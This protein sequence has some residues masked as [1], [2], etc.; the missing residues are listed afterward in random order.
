MNDFKNK[1]TQKS[2]ENFEKTNIPRPNMRGPR[3]GG[4]G[5]PGGF[6]P[7]DKVKDFKGTLKK[8]INYIGGYK[9][10]I[11]IVAVFAIFAAIFSIIGPKILGGATTEVFSGVMRQV[12]G[13]DG[14]DFGIIGNIILTLIILYLISALFSLLQGLIMTKISNNIT[15]KLRKEL[16]EKIYSLPFSYYD[17]T[18]NG[19]VLSRLT[20]DVDT[21]NQGLNQ[22]TTQIISSITTLVGVLIMMLT[23]SWQL[24][25]ITL[26]SL[27]ISG[28]LIA[29]ITKKS[30][31]KFVGQQRL[32]GKVNSIVE[33][34]YSCHTIVK[35]FGGEEKS[36]EQFSQDNNNLYKVAWQANFLSGLMW[37]ILIFVTNF[38][39]VLICIIGGNFAAAGTMSVGNIQ[40]FIQYIRTFNQ[41]IQQ[42]S[43]IS[44]VVQSTL[45]AAERVFG[46]LEEKEETNDV[47]NALNVNFTDEDIAGAVKIKG[48]VKF[49]DV[50]F[51]YLRDKIIV[52]DFT[53]T[54]KQGQKIAIVG[55]TGA[56]KTTIVK[57][58]MRFYDINSGSIMIDGHNICDFKREELRKIFGMVLQETW[59]YNGTIEENIRYG[60]LDASDEEV[61]E[62]AKI[63]G[64][65][66][67]IKTLPKG[68]KMELNEEAS[69]ISQ[70]Q[71]QLL[72][73]ARAV[74][75]N[76]KILI[77]DEATSSVDTRTEVLIQKAM[78]NLMN[79]RTSFIIAH[80]LSTIKNADVILVMKDGDIIEQGNHK[81]LMKQ[82]G[83]YANLYNSQFEKVSI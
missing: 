29:F 7:N 51:G 60:K 33:E 55:P 43:Q 65:H 23:I 10:G 79:G 47:E 5:G 72:T 1:N 48:N 20:N 13:G 6:N 61:V 41:P 54:V 62:A 82:N 44:T 14:I 3:S 38:S 32:L 36:F 52:N 78:D 70:G 15:Y 83:F 68:Y 19:D 50:N 34:N 4:P 35:A 30:Q 53:T 17:K 59:L 12:S 75:A 26:I 46:F 77:L 8:I 27:P 21:I 22:S 28:L 81:D 24:T 40:A 31:K 67:F 37:P 76:P 64:A 57:L 45:A 49:N 71:K 39:Y 11:I 16:S 9:F 25:L 58:L 69:N 18:T 2:P 73:I 56:G 74:L 63:A 66:H 42:I 80:R